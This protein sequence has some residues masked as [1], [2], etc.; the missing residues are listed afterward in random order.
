MPC[1]YT[2]DDKTISRLSNL[3]DRL[4]SLKIQ[5]GHTAFR[6]VQSLPLG[7]R[8]VVAVLGFVA[9]QTQ[10]LVGEKLPGAGVDG[11]A[12]GNAESKSSQLEWLW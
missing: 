5:H 3:Q 8:L 4:L 9:R 1:I 12:D 2:E 7:Y 6:H 11:S 10:G